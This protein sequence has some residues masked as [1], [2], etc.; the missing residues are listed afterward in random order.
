MSGADTAWLHMD[1]PNNLMVISGA[2]WFDEPVDWEQLREVVSSRLVERFPRFRQR[3]VDSRLPLR[4]PHWED[5]PD[6][7]LE[8]HLHRAALPVPGDRAALQ[9]FLTDLIA[10]PLDRSRPLWNWY[11]IDGY[12]SGSA[13]VARMHHCIADGIALARVLLSL[14][15]SSPEAGIEPGK[16]AETPHHGG[17]TGTVGDVLRPA[18]QAASLTR[19][20][21][22]AA[23]HEAIEIARDPSELVDLATAAS[24][25]AKALV[26]TLLPGADTPSVLKGHLGVPERVAW[27]DPI[28]LADVKAA[29][30][31]LDATV[32]DVLIAA[33]TGALHTYLAARD[34][35]VDELHAFVPFNLRPLDQPLPRHLGNRFGLVRLAIPVGTEDPYERLEQVRRG[36]T[37]IKHSPE[38]AVSYGMLGAIGATPAAIEQ[39]LLE[40]F[41][42][43]GSVVMT[44]VPGPREPV[45]LA[46]TPVRGVLVWAPTSGSVSMSVS[47]FSYN[48]EVT[49]GV[50]SDRGLVPDPGEIVA[51]FGR[52][53]EAMLATGA[54]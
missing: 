48:G 20:L 51:A 29:G 46:G 50:M 34:S 54:S 44:N 30:H 7:D 6:F 4:G 1:R 33:V 41:S 37:E 17:I 36:M 8:L 12:G 11:L 38:G 32:N 27:S 52:E 16:P 10:Q 15:D 24:L 28:P 45:Y 18:R 40:L 31:A 14:T 5:D 23:A 47:I 26:K 2:L 39:R 13:I 49:V 3:V 21:A 53:V 43:A 25:D 22:G 42:A 35:L 9:D 19:T